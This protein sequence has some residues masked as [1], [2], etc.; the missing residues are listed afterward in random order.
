VG[1]VGLRWRTRTATAA[2]AVVL[3]VLALATV[4]VVTGT[5]DLGADRI[6][7]ALTGNGSRIE[8]LVADRRLSRALVALLIGFALGCA[9]A[10]TQT[11]TRNPIASPDILGITAGAGAV[12]VLVV[13]QPQ[14]VRDLTGLDAAAALPLASGLGGLA[15]TGIVLGLGWRGGF[16][17]LRLV[18]V[19][20]GVNAVA[21]G[22]TSWLL[23]RASLDTAAVATRWLVGS[24]EGVRMA[25]LWVVVPPVLVAL[26]VVAYLSRDLA[27]LRLGHDVAAGLGTATGRTDLIAVLLAVALVSPATAVAGPIGFVAFVAPQAAMRLFGLPGPPP[28]AGGLFGAALLLAADMVAQRLPVPLPVGILTAAV[29]APCLLFLLIRSV[30]RTSV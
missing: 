21:V 24:L 9:G 28:V 6:W 4:A 11:V 23:T 7:A 1:P 10:L 18:L 15:A 12:A 5:L 13:S 8:E 14:L 27:A 30:R 29:G 16:D 26:P 22:V 19:G 17:G 3:L 25:D 20:L 2:L